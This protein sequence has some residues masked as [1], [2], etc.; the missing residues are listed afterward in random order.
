[1][2][3]LL[4]FFILQWNA[5]SLVAHGKELKHYI[6]NSTVKPD[7]IC[8]QFQEFANHLQEPSWMT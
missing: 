2:D 5:Q 1:M 6:Y 8:I 3:F 7:V 4:P